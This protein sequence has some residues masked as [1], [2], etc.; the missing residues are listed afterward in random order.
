[1]AARPIDPGNAFGVLEQALG[2]LDA[3]T[4]LVLA[5]LFVERLTVEETAQALGLEV[6]QVDR[7]AT[8]AR[9]RLA[10]RVAAR[11]EDRPGNRAA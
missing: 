3:D 1:M 4:R 8:L 2:S 11:T 6:S 10:A 9:D 5:L 7:A